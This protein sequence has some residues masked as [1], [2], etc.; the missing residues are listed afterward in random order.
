[1]ETMLAGGHGVI[2][3]TANVAPALMQSMCERALAG[4]R[5]AAE[6]LDERL[7]GLHKALFMES[8]PIPAKWALQQMSAI[9]S[10][11]RLPLTPL[12]ERCQPAVRDAMRLAETELA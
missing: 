4:D 12:S 6:V 3:V 2:S 10:G 7:Q 5:E 9:G 8:N 11:I 1:M